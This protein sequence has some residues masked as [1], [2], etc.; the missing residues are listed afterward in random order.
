[1]ITLRIIGISESI[2]FT[3]SS[4]QHNVIYQLLE[5][6]TTHSFS[7]DLNFRLSTNA[8]KCTKNAYK[9]SE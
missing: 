8:T 2:L 7:A 3:F 6:A 5:I 4:R 1:M 9:K